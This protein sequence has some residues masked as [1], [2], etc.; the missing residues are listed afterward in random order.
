MP[1]RRGSRKKTV[2]YVKKGARSAAYNFLSVFSLF[3]LV[4][5][6]ALFFILFQWKNFQIDKTL[7]EIDELRLQVLELN[8]RKSRLETRLN[9]LLQKV[10]EKASIVHGMIPEVDSPKKLIIDKKKLDYYEKKDRNILE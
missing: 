8:A 4:S 10:P 2:Y 9:D 3:I 1:V 6:V 7:K 5:F